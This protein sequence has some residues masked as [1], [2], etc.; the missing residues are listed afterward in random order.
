MFASQIIFGALV[1]FIIGKT[2][3]GYRRGTVSWS[4]TMVWFVFWCSVLI[5]LFN[6]SLLVAAAQFFSIG[7]GVDVAV[8][9]SI[10]VL[11]YCIYLLLVKVI[12]LERK[13]TRL[14][15]KQALQDHYGQKKNR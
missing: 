8:Y 15:R 1:V 9:L 7:R 11:F 2:I 4:F 12:S 14:V 13:L 3:I 6:Q 10:I 5:V